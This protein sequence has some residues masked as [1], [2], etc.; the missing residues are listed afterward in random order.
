MSNF[1]DVQLEADGLASDQ[2]PVSASNLT[3]A[4]PS[5]DEVAAMM[6]QF[7]AI[8]DGA[9]PRGTVYL[10]NPQDLWQI[11]P[12]A[13]QP[14]EREYQGQMDSIRM[15]AYEAMWKPIIPTYLVS[16]GTDWPLG[17]PSPLPPRCIPGA[18]PAIIAAVIALAV[19]LWAII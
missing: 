2:W 17:L 1:N 8:Y 16:C 6:K 15:R 7:N 18:V 3:S 14:H 13:I 5:F 4:S 12:L 9:V 11:K 10:F 19:L